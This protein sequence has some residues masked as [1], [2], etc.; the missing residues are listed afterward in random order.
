MVLED[1]LNTSL[2]LFWATF[3]LI[4]QSAKQ[5]AKLPYVKLAPKLTKYLKIGSYANVFS[6]FQKYK[7]LRSLSFY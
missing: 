5:G 2:T 7:S 6:S 4:I 1:P 3:L